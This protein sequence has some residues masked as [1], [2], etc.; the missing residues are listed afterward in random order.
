MVGSLRSTTA[1][2]FPQRHSFGPRGVKPS[3]VVAALPC[4]K[5]KGRIVAD[6]YL[7]VPG[8]TGLW[9]AGDSAAVPDGYETGIFFPPTAQHGMREAIVAAQNIERTILGQPLKPF[10][11]I[12]R[13]A[14]SRASVITP[15]WRV[16]W[17]QVL[18]LHRLVDVAL[19]LS[20][21]ASPPGE[22]TARHAGVDARSV[23][24]PRHRTT[25]HLA[26]C[27]RVE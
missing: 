12:A 17:I 13:W 2:R 8:F 1:C 3:P 24:R 7:Q 9:T 5:E 16:S 27:R 21:E 6:Q 23:I 10:L 11:A 25:D 20:R 22:E 14:C 19:G 26:R 18:R 15:A 4:A